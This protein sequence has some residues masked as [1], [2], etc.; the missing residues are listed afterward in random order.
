MFGMTDTQEFPWTYDQLQRY[1]VL[2]EF[3]RVFYSNERIKVLD[4]GGGSPER[5]GQFYWLPLKH[6]FAGTSLVI[7]RIHIE[8]DD[9]LQA[10]GLGLPVKNGSFDVV[11]ALDVIEHVPEKNR[12]Q[13]F[14]ELC[15]VSKS[16]VVL[17]APFR[18]E[19]IQRAEELLF[20]QIKRQYNISHQQLLEHKE[21][22]LPEIESVHLA[23][24]KH[25]VS[26]AGFGY[27]SLKNW[28]FVQTIK[29][30]FQFRKSSGGIQRVLDEWMTAYHRVSEFDPPYA[31]YFWMYSKSIDQEKL[32]NGVKIVKE[33]LKKKAEPELWFEDLADFNKDVSDYFCREVVSAI[34]VAS[35]KGKHLAECLN[36]VL[37][38]KVDFDFEVAVWDITREGAFEEMM[39]NQYP[40]VKY[41]GWEKNERSINGLLRIADELIGDYLLLVSDDILLPLDSVSCFRERLQASPEAGLLGPRIVWKRYFSPVYAGRTGSPGRVLAGRI[42]NPFKRHQ[43]KRARWLYSECLFFRKDLLYQRKAKSNTLKKRNIFLWERTGSGRDLLYAPDL[44]VHKKSR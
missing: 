6:V 12:S 23:L 16:S 44:V 30:C 42:I 13:L 36:H 18:D 33:N 32:E 7:D 35:G 4:V 3:I 43:E 8:K 40:G 10:D 22:G 14:L 26:G 28:I 37:T 21:Y 24:R 17:S 2:R 5:E 29:N 1:S 38:Q 41:L 9:Y 19:K 39:K 25:M 34:V 31:R 27:G 11:S 20:E 15:R